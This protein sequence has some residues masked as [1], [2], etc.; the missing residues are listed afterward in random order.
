MLSRTEARV[1]WGL[2]TFALLYFGG[3][4]LFAILRG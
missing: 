1:F 4:V 3:H 2:I